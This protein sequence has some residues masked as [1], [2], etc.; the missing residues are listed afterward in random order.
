[1]PEL[2]RTKSLLNIDK[3]MSNLDPQSMRYKVLEAAKN[4]KGSWFELGRYLYTV[5]K[6][7]LY[8]QWG[9][10]AFE[11]YCLKELG[12]RNQTAVKLLK[13]YYFV[14][15][16]EPDLI[17]AI[18]N[19]ES[20]NVL[21]LAKGNPNLDEEEYGK[22]KKDISSGQKDFREVGKQFRSMVKF[23]KEQN[24]PEEEHRKSFQRK[25]RSIISSL[26]AIKFES[27]IKSILPD[28]IF[29]QIDELVTI[30]EKKLE[31]L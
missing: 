6:D 13:S 8:R 31:E 24:N 10:M 2:I 27:E 18:P 29:K 14:E 19:Y 17:S 16:D 12:I 5:Y 22:L 28:K 3:Q 21:R 15:K 11:N 4:F 1:M 23:T 20:V 9:F 26:K 30:L 7:K 25:I